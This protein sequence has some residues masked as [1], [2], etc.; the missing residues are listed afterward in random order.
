MANTSPMKR[1]RN[2]AEQ[3]FSDTTRQLGNAQQTYTSALKQ[4]E[5]LEN[6]E[7]EYQQ[8]LQNNIV[9]KGISVIDLLTRQS[10]ISS[11]RNV[12][13]QHSRHVVACQHSVEQTLSVWKYDKQRLNAFDVLVNRTDAARMLKESR[14]EQKLMDEFAQR[15]GL[16]S[17]PL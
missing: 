8:Q 6:Y 15:A 9:D 12:V 13:K 17:K 4:L 1:L 10:F 16:R 5:Q 7:Q 11:L 14:Q 3:T 2:L